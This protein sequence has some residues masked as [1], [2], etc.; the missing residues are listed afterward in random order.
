MHNLISG[1]KLPDDHELSKFFRI[2]FNL[3]SYE[4]MVRLEKAMQNHIR[5]SK[6]RQKAESEQIN[7]RS[8]ASLH[9]CTLAY[10]LFLS[11][12]CILSFNATFNVFALIVSPRIRLFH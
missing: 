11:F 9:T 7:V 4:K 6:C 3:N 12:N 5:F 8:H 2:P 1:R 10:F